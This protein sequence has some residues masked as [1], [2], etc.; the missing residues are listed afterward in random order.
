MDLFCEVLHY[1]RCIAK[2][3]IIFSFFLDWGPILQTMSAEIFPSLLHA[4][5]VAYTTMPN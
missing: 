1:I 5:G 4:K 2:L 3:M